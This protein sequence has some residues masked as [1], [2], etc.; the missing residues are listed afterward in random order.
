MNCPLPGR[1]IY[2]FLSCLDG[3]KDDAGKKDDKP[4]AEAN[5]NKTGEVLVQQEAV[6]F[7]V[8]PP[9]D[10]P[11]EAPEETTDLAKLLPSDG[12][13]PDKIEIKASSP[14]KLSALRE[15]VRNKIAAG[16]RGDLQS[17]ISLD[18]A[19]RVTTQS[20]FQTPASGQS[21]KLGRSSSG[22]ENASS[23]TA[24]GVGSSR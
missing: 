22:L 14:P 21:D 16:G 18:Q 23:L 11:P 9:P 1:G 10:N 2:R 24:S 8:L 12:G 13:V 17:T 3:K 6:P 20:M 4:S 15:Q 19:S 5:Q 7:K